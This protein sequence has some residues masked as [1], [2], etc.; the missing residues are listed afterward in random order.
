MSLGQ[1]VKRQREKIGLTQDQVA[2]AAGISKPYLSNIETGKAKNPPTD[3]VLQ[4]LEKAMAFNPGELTAM[5][6]LLKTPADVRQKHE[7]LQAEVEKLR[8]VLKGLMHGGKKGARKPA[9][10]FPKHLPA[11]SAASA[12]SNVW[13]I[14]CGKVVPIINSV[15][16]GYPHNF[17]DLDYPPSVADEYI[18]CPDLHDPQ[19]FGAR[20]VGDSMEPDYNQ[21]DIVIFSP[22]T[23]PKNGDDCFVRFDANACWETTFKRFYQDTADSIRLQ[24]LN[25]KYASQVY[26]SSKITGLWPAVLK[27]QKL[28]Q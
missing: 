26:P 28:R 8:G 16:A 3:V 27:I 10:K 17:T 24:P 14:A 12:D 7:E 11:K 1:F 2:A 20:I 21:G 4:M 23:A 25:S 6:H 13:P 22:N 15:A 18:R 9:K 5:A 19:A